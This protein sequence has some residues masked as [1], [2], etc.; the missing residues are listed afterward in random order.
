MIYFLMS[1]IPLLF[2]TIIKS[3]KSIHMLQQN[4]YDESNRYLLWIKNN[5][6]KV[7]LSWDIVLF[8]VLIGF[9]L[10]NCITMILFSLLT[11]FAII[12]IKRIKEQVKKPLVI[13]SR[14][15]RMFITESILYLII[16]FVMIILYSNNSIIIYYLVLSIFI[17]FLNNNILKISLNLDFSFY[18]IIMIYTLFLYLWSFNNRKEN[19]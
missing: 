13:T 7:F 1:L 18:K 8:I 2:L 14:V 16:L 4:Y 12:E 17:N 9:I 19:I 11:I 10:N 15:K 3:K 6:K 5:L